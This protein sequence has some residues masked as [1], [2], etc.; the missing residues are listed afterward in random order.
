MVGGEW[1]TRVRDSPTT[2]VLRQGALYEFH[3]MSKGEVVC[4]MV[5]ALH[6]RDVPRVTAEGRKERRHRGTAMHRSIIIVQTCEGE[7]GE[8]ATETASRRT[9]CIG[10]RSDL[11]AHAPHCALRISE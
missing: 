1:Q 6:R 7:R 3:R 11:H 4:A 2:K 9:L 10:A 5:R 8:S